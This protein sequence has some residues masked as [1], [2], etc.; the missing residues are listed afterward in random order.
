MAAKRSETLVQFFAGVT[1]YSFHT[2]VGITDP[3][4]VDYVTEMLVRFV[5]CDTVYRVRDLSG[6]KLDEV[7]GM[8]IEAEER[9]GEARREVH[10]HVGDY[11]LF[12][13][14]LYPEALEAKQ[15]AGKRDHFLDYCREGKKA[16][17]I[18]STIPADESAPNAEVLRRLSREF[19]T[20][21]YGLREVRREW[22]RR[23]DTPGDG[24]M[25][26]N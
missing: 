4:L 11:A 9:L 1:E 19:E 23:D 26:L 7:A 14:G 3:P 8:L 22:E 2:Q 13:A 10:R 15:A 20:C 21:V 12:W 16:Y 24:P 6:Q 5:H 18:A 25:L 17:Y